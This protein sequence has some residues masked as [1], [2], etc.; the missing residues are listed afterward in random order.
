MI[1]PRSFIEISW[2][3]GAMVGAAFVSV[4]AQSAPTELG[5]IFVSEYGPIG[6]A[7]YILYRRMD[8]LQ[9]QVES[10]TENIKENHNNAS[11]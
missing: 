8:K 3:I 9:E 1:D 4:L 5:Q 6:V 2:A 7:V 11:K 10:N